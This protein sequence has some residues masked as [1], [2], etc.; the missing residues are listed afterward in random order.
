VG[1]LAKQAEQARN[2][3]VKVVHGYGKQDNNKKSHHALDLLIIR[4]ATKL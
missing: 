4:E 3:R 1:E 2:S